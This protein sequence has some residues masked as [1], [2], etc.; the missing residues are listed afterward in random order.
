MKGLVYDIKR[1][2]IH[3]G[4]GI[5]TAFHFKGCPLRCL[6]CHNPESWDFE[7]S[8]SYSLDRCIGCG[9]CVARCPG[10]ALSLGEALSIQRSSCVRCGAC[11]DV[12][13]T[14]ALRLVG[15][16]MT[17]EELLREAQKDE[18]FFDQSGGG[19]TLSG[20][21]PLSQG[22]FLLACISALKGAGLRV[23]VDTSGYASL[24]LALQVA[25]Q[26]DLVLYDL[27]HM[28]DASHRHLT[29]VGNGPIL[30]NLA[31]MAGEGLSEKIWIRFPLIPS[32]N[33]DEHNL[34]SMG[35]FMLSLG[36]RRISVLPYHS[37][38]VHKYRHCGLENGL[39]RVAPVEPPSK[40][41]VAQVAGHL[42]SMGLDV[43]V[44]G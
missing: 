34:N 26:S 4:P 1:Y 18:I 37:A 22:E 15:F 33:D 6:W 38:G 13:P 20:G 11:A 44:G 23:A 32:L 16:H 27:K 29:G 14:G 40:D 10:G 7:P 3:D 12:C 39:S 9:A 42:R 2:S 31:A 19:V 17:P 24:D 5:R 28:D 25:S 36:L 8:I 30:N 35:S 41:R 43:K 21:E